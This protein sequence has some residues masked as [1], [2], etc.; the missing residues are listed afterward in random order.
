MF[1]TFLFLFSEYIPEK[2]EVQLNWENRGTVK[3]HFQIDLKNFDDSVI[4]DSFKALDYHLFKLNKSLFSVFSGVLSV[5]WW[6]TWNTEWLK[7]YI[8]RLAE[9]MHISLNKSGLLWWVSNCIH[10]QG[11]LSIKLK[12]MIPP[13]SS[14][15]M[16][17]MHCTPP[18]YST[19]RKSQ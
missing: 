2:I 15:D 13:K 16:F 1:E 5:L 12:W 9:T 17:W 18:K 10:Q 19:G 4:S 6:Y 3:H 8:L 14:Q 7:M 11:C